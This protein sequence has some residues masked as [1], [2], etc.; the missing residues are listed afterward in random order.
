M[1]CPTPFSTFYQETTRFLRIG[2]CRYFSNVTICGRSRT[3]FGEHHS[4]RKGEV[5]IHGSI[6]VEHSELVILENITIKHCPSNWCLGFGSSV[7]VAVRNVAISHCTR[8]GI[9]AM[10]CENTTITQSKITDCIHG[11]VLQGC[12]SIETSHLFL[13]RMV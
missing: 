3:D 9:I 6:G 7:G 11:M 2:T 10:D 1:D 13:S 5:E 4:I 8:D 12:M